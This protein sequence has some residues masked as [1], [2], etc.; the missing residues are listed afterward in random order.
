MKIDNA[1]ILFL[2][3]VSFHKMNQSS[4]EIGRLLIHW[5]V[6]AFRYLFQG[7]LKKFRNAPAR[8]Y[9]NNVIT[10]PREHSK[11]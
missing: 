11:P 7:Y 9:R 1:I 3:V 5:Q 10:V 6:S 4:S 2:K 8:P